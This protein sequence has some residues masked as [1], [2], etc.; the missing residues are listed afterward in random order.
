[1]NP[2]ARRTFQP[3]LRRNDGRDEASFR[4]GRQEDAMQ[5]LNRCQA[6]RVRTAL[7]GQT[8]DTYSQSEDF[9]WAYG[10]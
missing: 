3:K 7:E 1:M 6:P 9:G 2:A 4:T 5:G 10:G 8:V